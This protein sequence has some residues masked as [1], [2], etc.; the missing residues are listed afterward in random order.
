MTKVLKMSLMGQLQLSLD[1]RPLTELV[2]GKGQALLCYLAVDGRSHTRQTLAGLLW[3]ELPEEDARRNLRG[4]LMKLRELFHPHLHITH[5]TI[6]FNHQSLHWLDVTTFRAQTHYRPGSLPTPAQLR[7]AVALY[8][9]EFLEDFYVR[10][11]PLFEEWVVRL[12]RELHGTALQACRQLMIVYSQQGEDNLGM[13]YAR[14]LLE[15]DPLYEEGHRQMMWLLAQSGNRSS[16]LGQYELCRELLL[17]E[18]GVLP[19]SET[20]TLYEQIRD[21]KLPPR[22]LEHKKTAVKTSQPVV[23]SPETAVS[24]SY[25]EPPPFIVGPP[26]VH[27]ARFFGRE[28][29]LKRLFGLL[30]QVPL[31]NSAIIGPRR[32]GKTSLL[33]YLKTVTTAPPHQLRP[34][35]KT[36]WLPANGRYRWIFVDFQ[37]PRLG[38]SDGLLRYLLLQLGLPVPPTCTL[39]YFLDVVSDSLNRPTVILFDEIEVALQRYPELDDTFWEGLRSLATNQVG[40]NLAFV[41]AGSESPEQLASHRGFGSPFFNIFGYTAT[42]GPL[43]ETEAQDLITSSPIPFAPEDV[44][45]IVTESGRWPMLLQI[46]CRERLLSL[47]D[48]DSGPSWRTDALQQM[49]PFKRGLGLLPT[50]QDGR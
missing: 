17:T 27:P 47:E 37:D 26:I 29:E 14:R 8:R 10:Q 20:Y 41:L 30:R 28:R 43:S 35:Q 13:E 23:R 39:D 48:G 12:R 31:Q 46:L 24:L 18:L 33:H 34:H 40:G 16:A 3:G 2:S 44:V 25:N 38:G 49:M 15:I 45:W 11:A 42:L 1:E 22:E 9:G 36:D 32:S 19:A 7:E 6:A 4:V 50:E 21:G 5:Q